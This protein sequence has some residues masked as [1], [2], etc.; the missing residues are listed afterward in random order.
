M[1]IAKSY[2]ILSLLTSFHSVVN[3][4][5]AP[6][7]PKIISIDSDYPRD[8]IWVRI[9]K[10]T[11]KITFYVKAEHTETVL[12]WL[13][14]TGTQTWNLRELIGYDIKKGEKDNEFSLT[15]NVDQ[16]SL[17]NHLHI[18]ALGDGIANETINLIME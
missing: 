17:L 10:G 7:P 6:Q 11:K 15:W 1:I 13:M 18:Q 2:L 8:G 16:P 4:Q 5:V 14:P 3:H 12:F 9:P